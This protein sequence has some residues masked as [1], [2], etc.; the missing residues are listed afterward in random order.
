MPVLTCDQAKL[1]G[2]L[3]G[4][5]ELPVVADEC[6]GRLAGLSRTKGVRKQRGW[7]QYPPLDG[8]V[9]VGEKCGVRK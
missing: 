7:G 2:A 5:V 8:A 3:T 4:G 9:S 6:S 1:T